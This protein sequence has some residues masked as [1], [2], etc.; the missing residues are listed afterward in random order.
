[1]LDRKCQQD[2]KWDKDNFS[3]SNQLKLV[4]YSLVKKEVFINTL[5]IEIYNQIF[6]M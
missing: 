1:M 3:M 2:I 5:K 6:S 4:Q